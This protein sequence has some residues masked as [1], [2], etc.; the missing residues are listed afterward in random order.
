MKRFIEGECRTQT[1]LMPECLDDYITDTNPVRVVDV[2]VDELD[3]YKLGYL[4]SL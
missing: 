1:T 2:F 4:L 3:L